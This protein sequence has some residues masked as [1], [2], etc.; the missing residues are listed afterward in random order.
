MSLTPHQAKYLAY[1]LTRRGPAN[2]IE[3]FAGTKVDFSKIMPEFEY[4]LRAD[5]SQR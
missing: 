5:D 1:E 4:A 2:T 3:K